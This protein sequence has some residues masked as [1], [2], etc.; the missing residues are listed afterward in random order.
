M[1]ARDGV[2]SSG[3]DG[4]HIR[5]RLHI[6]N[7][8]FD[9]PDETIRAVFGRVGDVL[10]VYIPTDHNTGKS[11]GFAFVTMRTT[12]DAENAISELDGYTVDGRC[13]RVNVARE[14]SPAPAARH[15]NGKERRR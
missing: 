14:Q 4:K 2:N 7:L 10:E 6:G 12:M 5:T 1:R 13:I 3:H 9:T 8:S 11:R 15:S